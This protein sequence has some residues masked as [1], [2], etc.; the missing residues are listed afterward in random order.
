MIRSLAHIEPSAPLEADVA[1]VGA[2]LAG[3]TLADRLHR[4]GLR[5]IILES[6]SER[7]DTDHHPLNEVEMSGS[8]YKGARDGRF[9][10]LGGTSTRWGGALLPYLDPDLQ[11]HPLGW[12]TGWGIEPGDLAAKRSAVESDFAVRQGSYEPSGIDR[13]ESFLPRMPK[14]PAFEMRNMG[15]ICDSLLR[16]SNGPQLWLDATVTGI[17]LADGRL[18][19]IEARNLNGRIISVKAPQVVLAAGAIETTRLL[20]LFQRTHGDRL[21][22]VDTPLGRGF[23][24]HLS[25]AVAEIVPTSLREFTRMFSFR[26]VQGGMRNLRFELDPSLRGLRKLPSAFFHVAFTRPEGGSFDAL[27]RVLS[28]SQQRR[29]PSFAD[30]SRI[31]LDAPW[32]L[33]A[34]WWRFVERR[35][36]PPADAVYQLHFVIEQEPDPSN[37]I[38]LSENLRDAFGQSMAKIFWRISES[39]RQALLRG[40]ALA[41]EEW[42][43]GPLSRFGQ[44]QRYCEDNILNYL[45]SGGG[46]FHPAG[47]TRIGQN[48][49]DG[50]VD[51]ELRVHGLPGLW[52]VATSVFPT[53]GGSSPSLALMEL[54]AR[55]ADRIIV[56][57]R[58]GT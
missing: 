17:S 50:V 39:D 34:V 10:C 21:F 8:D 37:R 38:T 28:A 33:R 18:E 41:V 13:L 22:P 27:R 9:R 58:A 48:A 11:A 44:A 51:S 16:N 54:A 1:I 40:A 15:K 46:I 52:A 42:N 43:E 5:V 3:L 25:A 49:H 35:V 2:G 24:D 32:F 29:T 6:G 19:C 23:H 7:Q 26:F 55:A 31:G 4:A 53:I 12:H 20:L 45:A 30:L 57:M 56:E 47:T 14:W 36:L